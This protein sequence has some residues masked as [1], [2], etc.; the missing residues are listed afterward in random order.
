MSGLSFIGILPSLW[1]DTTR[2]LAGLAG[3]GSLPGAV[4][5]TQGMTG[6]KS[7]S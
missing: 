3:M 2:S 4:S 7:A 5:I 6:T 1:L